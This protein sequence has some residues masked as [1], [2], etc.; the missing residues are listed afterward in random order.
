[1]GRCEEILDIIT[2]NTLRALKTVDDKS[3]K[4]MKMLNTFLEKKS[5]LLKPGRYLCLD[6]KGKYYRL[7]LTTVSE[8][9]QEIKKEEE[10][11]FISR[12][13]RSSNAETGLK[14]SVTAIANDAVCV[15]F[16]CAWKDND[17]ALGLKHSHGSNICCLEKVSDVPK[18]SRS[19]NPGNSLLL[20]N[21]EWGQIGEDGCLDDYLTEYDKL[22][23]KF[24][25]EPGCCM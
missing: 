23:D 22:I 6:F 8:D 20:L 25:S 21:A 3:L 15:F 4:G 19:E 7:V 18:L 24:S 2:D 1:M 11:Y 17:C 5:G 10:Y 16:A 12:Q 14:V 9:I 13:L